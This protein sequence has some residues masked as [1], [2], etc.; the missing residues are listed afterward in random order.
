MLGGNEYLLNNIVGEDLQR[1]LRPF[2]L[3]RELLLVSK[4]RIKNNFITPRSRMYHVLSLGILLVF[5]YGYYDI[6]DCIS[7]GRCSMLTYVIHPVAYAMTTATAAYHSASA[8]ELVI[9]MQRINKKLRVAGVSNLLHRSRRN[10]YYFICVHFTHISKAILVVIQINVLSM[11]TRLLSGIIM[12]LEILY[13]TFIVDF[14]SSR[15]DSWITVFG[16][17]NERLVIIGGVNKDSHNNAPLIFGII[18]DIL[19]AFRIHK[20]VC[21]S[22]V[23]IH[24]VLTFMQC[25]LGIEVLIAMSKNQAPRLYGLPKVHKEGEPFRPVVSYVQA[26][27][28]KLGKFDWNSIGGASEIDIVSEIEIR[29]ENST[30]RLAKNVLRL[31]SKRYRKMRACGFFTVDAALPLRLLALIT[32]YCIVLLQ[33]AFFPASKIPGGNEYL[34]NNAVGE[35]LQRA[36]KP[37]YLVKELFLVSNYRIRDNFITPRP[38][39]GCSSITYA[40]YPVA[41]ATI[42]ATKAYYSAYAVK[43]VTKMQGINKKLRV[44]GA[45][46]FLQVSRKNWCYA[47]CVNLALGMSVLGMFSTISSIVIFILNLSPLICSIMLSTTCERFDCGVG[48]VQRACVDILDVP[49]CTRELK[50]GRVLDRHRERDRYSCM[51][52]YQDLNQKRR[53]GRNR[54]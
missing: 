35:D 12:D 4:Y 50:Q 27:T 28:H 29:S 18:K 34:L 16:N 36:L 24:S 33:F 21:Q 48:R 11:Y 43:L 40:F 13:A 42:M 1:A 10:W 15:M 23:L 3:V 14:L 30:R 32:T 5:L 9:K 8:V 20:N 19:E 47:V 44:A 7:Y 52:R 46:N 49:N 38:R 39:K 45:P 26:P 6:S 53:G 17:A 41:Y 51:Y 37:F 2:D 25:L 54:D 22:V 31:C